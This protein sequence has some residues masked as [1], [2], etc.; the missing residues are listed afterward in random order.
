MRIQIPVIFL[1]SSLLAFACF[2]YV[3]SAR[4][5]PIDD[6][7]ILTYLDG[8]ERLSL[9]STFRLWR[10]DLSNTGRFH[11][12]YDFLRVGETFIF[13]KTIV[14][15][16]LLRILILAFAF[17]TTWFLI[18]KHLGFVL[19]FV[20]AGTSFSQAFFA[21]IVGRLG[22]AE[23]YALFFSSLFALAFFYIWKELVFELKTSLRWWNLLAF[24]GS[25]AILSKENMLIIF[26]PALVLYVVCFWKRKVTMTIAVCFLILL[27]TSTWVI[28]GVSKIQF[29]KGMDVY[30]NTI[31]TTDQVSTLLDGLRQKASIVLVVAQGIS[32]LAVALDKHQRKK[33]I[34]RLVLLFVAWTFFIS[35]Y[36]FYGGQWPTGSR[37]DF[38]GILFRLIF[39][40]VSAEWLLSFVYLKWKDRR[41]RVGAYILVCLAFIGFLF[42][43]EE[44]ARQ[45]K[46]AQDYVQMTI[47]YQ[48]SLEFVESYS[49][50]YPE[51]DII[52][53]SSSPNDMEFIH[54][55]QVHLRSRKLHPRIFLRDYTG[56]GSMQQTAKLGTDILLPFSQRSKS[57][58]SIFF[59]VRVKTECR[60]LF[61]FDT[62]FR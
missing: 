51:T 57:C 1:V 62:T 55:I 14:L 3:F 33:W 17:G 4:M 2:S 43:T 45:S 5:S 9:G 8:R 6:H 16:Y 48:K 25:L 22:P 56:T 24:S 18:S 44:F 13:G 61:L 60:D 7:D 37:Y 32:G 21:D 35:Q 54:A 10:R 39:L 11:P 26:L 34:T 15:W 59:A 23:S 31:S 42:K 49:K 50:E 58:L 41:I 53:E 36:V 19:S 47:R 52:L 46:M 27:A 30:G 20:L 28:L 38:P 40:V 12:A 29:T